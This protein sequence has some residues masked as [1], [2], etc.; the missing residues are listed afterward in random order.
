VPAQVSGAGNRGG[1]QGKDLGDRPV[2]LR[3]LCILHR[4]LPDKVPRDGP[5][6]PGVHDGPG[7]ALQGD[8]GRTQKEGTGAGRSGKAGREEGIRTLFFK[9]ITNT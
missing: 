2:P 3:H 4:C 6:V 5:A 7:R 1:R 8:G 9:K